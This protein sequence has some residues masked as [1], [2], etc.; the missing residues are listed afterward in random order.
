MCI[1]FNYAPRYCIDMTLLINSC[2]I[3]AAHIFLFAQHIFL[4]LLS[5]NVKF[6]IVFYVF[7]IYFFIFIRSVH[8][9]KEISDKTYQMS[10]LSKMIVSA[11]SRSKQN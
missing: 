2:F 3:R 11:A 10:G 8:V 6:I 9:V 1:E 5:S 4:L 7:H